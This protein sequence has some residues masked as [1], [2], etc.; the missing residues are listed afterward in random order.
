[1]KGRLLSAALAAVFGISLLPC[2][3]YGETSAFTLDT[4]REV[5]ITAA[6]LALVAAGRYEV[7]QTHAPDPDGLSRSGVPGIDRW[8]LGRY[9]PSAGTM[10]D[11]TLAACEALSLLV[12]A[13]PFFGNG[14]GLLGKTL[15][16][17]VMYGETHL[18]V[19]GITLLAKGTARRSRPY[20]YGSTAPE[21][22]KRA[23]DAA[24]SFWSGH[25]ANAFACA[26]FAGYVFENQGEFPEYRL[27]VWIAG[28]SA[29]TATSILRVRAGQHFPTDVIAGA[30]AGSFAGW[31]IPR[32]HR[33]RGADVSL[34]PLM[35]G[36]T[37][38]RVRMTFR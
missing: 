10:S 28:L 36:V 33:T 30:A 12:V 11:R 9:S 3:S 37:G 29:A 35:G 8:A 32:L 16:A 2:V 15:T 26:V 34:V 4:A 27:P 14:G 38:F 5:E 31:F 1:M 22:T 6:S 17:G 13:S 20:S 23:R 19:E 21:G 24:L 7:L 18:F 25:A